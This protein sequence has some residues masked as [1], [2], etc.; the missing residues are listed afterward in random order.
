MTPG[1]IMLIASTPH[2]PI[3]R[4]TAIRRILRLTMLL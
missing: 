1:D 4:L 3:A 2:I